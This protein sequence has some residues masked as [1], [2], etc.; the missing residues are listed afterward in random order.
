MW[1]L[2]SANPYRDLLEDESA[3]RTISESRRR[4]TGGRDGIVDPSEESRTGGPGRR[5]CRRGMGSDL[6]EPSE[7]DR[8]S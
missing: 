7:A 2:E 3:Y 6:G 1:I 4:Q 8:W 5:S